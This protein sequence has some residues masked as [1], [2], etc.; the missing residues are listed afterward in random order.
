MSDELPPVLRALIDAERAAPA[1][2]DRAAI[3]QRVLATVGIATTV[4]GASTAT[5]AAATTL[6]IG[7]K[8]VGVVLIAG[9]IGGGTALLARDSQRGAIVPRAAQYEGVRTDVAAEPR[10]AAAPTLSAERP[11]RSADAPKP[12][13]AT[14]TGA[15]ADAHEPSS[16]DSAATTPSRSTASALAPRVGG[17][18]SVVESHASLLERAWQA[19]RRGDHGAVLALVER[20]AKTHPTGVLREERDALHIDALLKL[21]RTD[22]ARSRAATFSAHFPASL[23]RALVAPAMEDR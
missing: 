21:G 9:A 20:D 23:H 16:A 17:S 8:L 7:G 12:S 3:K 4:A 5:A 2:G 1:A 6:G 15:P 11:T 18:A 22:E 13:A 14:A 10:V 19:H